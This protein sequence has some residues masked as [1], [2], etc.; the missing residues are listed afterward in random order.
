MR[1]SPGT[2]RPTGRGT[3]RH[4]SGCPSTGA[5]DAVP[6]RDPRCSPVR[7]LVAA[8]GIVVAI[9]VVLLAG[10]APLFV[11]RVLA[12]GLHRRR[13]RDHA[14][15]P[16][17]RPHPGSCTSSNRAPRAAS[18][19]CCGAHPRLTP[20][21]SQPSWWAAARPGEVQSSRS[22]ARW[23]LGRPP[24]TCL[25]APYS[26]WNGV[27]PCRGR[28]ISDFR[29]DRMLPEAEFVHA[30]AGRPRPA[31]R[32]G[33]RV[34]VGQRAAVGRRER[35]ANAQALVG[36]SRCDL[37][38]AIGVWHR[39]QSRASRCRV[40]R[41]AAAAAEAERDRLAGTR[42]ASLPRTRAWVVV[43]ENR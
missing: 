31:N 19:A 25:P 13:V 24:S 38:A 22:Y 9:G 30:D 5:G 34:S 20:H 15:R 40:V 26:G 1:G 37:E 21:S 8:Y 12:G 3:R 42:V 32:T 14:G 7:A 43:P 27:R 18:S 36:V 29:A 33:P 41:V 17:A 2:P 35:S 11:Q 10:V 23:R 16:L 28:G 4:E 6:E 39:D